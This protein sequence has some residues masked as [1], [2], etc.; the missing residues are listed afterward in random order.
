MKQW[1]FFATA[2]KGLE[3]LLA[4]ELRAL[5][6]LEVRE[7]HGGAAF[8]GPLA[9]GY[10]ACLWS[11]LASRVLLPLATFPAPDPDAL[12]AGVREIPWEEHLP[13][14]GTLAVDAVVASS[15]ISH[16]MYAALKVKDAVV[17]RFRDRCGERPGVDT[18]RPDLRLNLYLHR[19]QATL[20]IDLSGDSLHR[21]GYRV[22]G[23]AAPLKENLAAA[24][25]LRAGWPEIAAAGGSLVDPLCGSGTLV[26]E[27][28]L[29]AGDIAPGLLREHFGFFGW[30]GHQ[31]APWLELLAEAAARRAAGLPNIPTLFGYDANSVAV[32]AAVAN[33]ARLGLG[34][35]VQFARRD[36]AQLANPVPAAPPGLVIAN[37]PYGERLGEIAELEPLYASLGAGL[38]SHFPGWRAA[39]FTGNPQLGRALGLRAKRIHAFFNGPIKC[40]LLHFDLFAETPAIPAAE[41]PRPLSD[42]AQM[43][44]NRL[45]KNLKH[46]ERWARRESLECYRLYDAD[47][48][49]YAVAVDRYGDYLHVQEYAPPVTVDP[50]QAKVR[51]RE[52]LAAVRAVFDVPRERVILK[53]RQKQKG[54]D[55]YRKLAATGDFHEVREGGCRF[56]VNLRDYLDTGL[57][58]DHRPTRKL[59]GELA[60]G[61]DFLNLFAYTGT[62][63][64]HAGLG[65]ARSTVSVDLSRTYLDW[66]RRNLE[67]NGLTGPNHRLIQGDVLDWVNAERGR[68]GLIFLD[69]PTFSNSKRMDATFDVQR[70]H[71]ALLTSV[72]RLLTSDGILIFSNNNRR[73][74]LDQ[75]S[76]SDLAI[77]DITPA[78]IPPDFA[79]NPRIHSCWRMTRATPAD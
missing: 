63:T 52:A 58:L 48:P 56:L 3:T 2:P 22:D 25:L 51:L 59:L 37:P 21:R 50:H 12:Y 26:L 35:R 62:A 8:V 41:A 78:T 1:D 57:F 55:Q 61:R 15:G 38:R 20:S 28:A 72:A 54:A 31:P 45:R 30:L 70:D 17:D 36:L 19:D 13:V 44:A 4:D 71:V 7:T 60:A 23:A 40:Q 73:F 14:T 11:R 9:A 18:E 43:V 34:E 74:R 67:L 29:L 27:G 66:A 10:R 16:S 77:V 5:G 64:V 6:A 46:L 53:V 39:V 69:P 68:Y 33:V 47:L 24:L 42:G 76:L 49:E 75:E 32:R 65:G 79:R